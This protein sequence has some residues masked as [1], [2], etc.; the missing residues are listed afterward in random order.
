MGKKCLSANVSCCHRLKFASL[1]HLPRTSSHFGIL[2]VFLTIL[3][4]LQPNNTKW[5][6]QWIRL[7]GIGWHPVRWGIEHFYSANDITYVQV[8][9]TNPYTFTFYPEIRWYDNYSFC[10][11]LVQNIRDTGRWH[12]CSKGKVKWGKSLSIALDEKLNKKSEIC[13]KEK[14]NIKFEICSKGKVK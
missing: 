1:L 2:V 4:K 3:P 7:G 8:D 6:Y 5:C 10:C 12:L 9:T 13:S 11:T 14:L